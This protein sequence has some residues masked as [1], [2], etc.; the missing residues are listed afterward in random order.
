[1]ADTQPLSA[2]ERRKL[3]SLLKVL[4]DVFG[5]DGGSG[6][7]KFLKA[8]VYVLA[9]II[10]ASTAIV[11]AVLPRLDFAAGE[12]TLGTLVLGDL[13]VW[14]SSIVFLCTLFVV[15]IQIMRGLGKYRPPVAQAAPYVA[16]AF[17]IVILVPGYAAVETA[18]CGG[19]AAM[20]GEQGLATLDDHVP[21]PVR[22]VLG[23]GNE[24]EDWPA[25]LSGPAPA[26]GEPPPGGED[27]PAAPST[28]AG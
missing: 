1:M 14:M 23:C 13:V 25:A 6:A 10:V 28:G 17:L 24:S 20:A 26:P 12:P 21:A 22:W 18:V 27:P 11:A 2:D 8:S 5:T 7:G 19:A 9:G 3:K 15:V 4:Q 16:G